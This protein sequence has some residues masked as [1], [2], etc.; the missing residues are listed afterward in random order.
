MRGGTTVVLRQINLKIASSSFFA[1]VLLSSSL[2]FALDAGEIY[3]KASPAVVLIELY[4]QKGEVEKTGSGF[5]VSADGKI[6]TN[7]HVIAHSKQ[8]TVRLAN[9]DAYDKVDVIDID[10]R[11]DI[12]L[13]KI[14]GID[15]P[16]LELGKSSSV[17]VGDALYALSNPLGVLTNSLSHGI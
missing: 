8:A 16:F 1:T 5:L 13:I 10:K 3:K 12:A 9:G 6:L 4:N 15:L 2:S 11:K 14:R 7:Y 17:Q